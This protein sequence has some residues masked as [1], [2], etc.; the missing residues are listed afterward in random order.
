MTKFFY[1]INLLY[2]ELSKILSLHLLSITDQ[3]VKNLLIRCHFPTQLSSGLIS[4]INLL[5]IKNIN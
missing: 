5:S 4:E 3:N 1:S 2:F